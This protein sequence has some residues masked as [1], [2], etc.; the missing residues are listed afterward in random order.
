MA[1]GR[2]SELTGWPGPY[3][4]VAEAAGSCA[5]TWP[6]YAPYYTLRADGVAWA[7]EPALLGCPLVPDVPLLAASIAA[8]EHHGPHHA[9]YEHIHLVA[10]GLRLLLAPGAPPQLVDGSHLRPSRLLKQH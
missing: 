1:A 7:G 2:W 10:G 6:G 5:A 8:G 9:P 4:V 3:W